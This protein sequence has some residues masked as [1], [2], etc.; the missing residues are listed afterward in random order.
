MSSGTRRESCAACIA[1]HR[2]RSWSWCS[3]HLV[4]QWIKGNYKDA[5]WFAWVTGVPLLWL[6]Y[7][8]GISGYW[9]VWDS[10]AQYVAVAT[11]E[12]LDTLPLFGEPIARNFLH[13]STLSGR[14]FTLMVFIHIAVPLTMLFLMWVHIQRHMYPR[15]NPPRGLMIGTFGMLVVLSVVY[16]A[17]SQDKADLNRVVAQV[18]LDWFYLP[19]TRCWMSTPVKSCGRDWP[20]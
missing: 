13:E 6:M 20:A 9:I 1:T 8:S 11:T 3:A 12:W 7:A 19:C 18:G 16:P 10:L 15:V 5:R 14:F 17:V 2:T 4:R